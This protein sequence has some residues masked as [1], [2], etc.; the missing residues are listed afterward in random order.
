MLDFINNLIFNSIHIY[1][2]QKINK[3]MSTHNIMSDN[4]CSNLKW[5]CI[6][7]SDLEENSIPHIF[8]FEDIMNHLNESFIKDIYPCEQFDSFLGI[9]KY[10][11][12]NRDNYNEIHKLYRSK[13]ITINEN[14][15][16]FS[17]NVH[18]IIQAAKY[19]EVD[20][21]VELNKILSVNIECFYIKELENTLM[22]EDYKSFLFEKL[23]KIN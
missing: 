12:I 17:E 10:D 4:E 11:T 7:N 3:S 13:G 15:V 8:Y 14:T 22:D 19:K 23:N 16:D 21:S 6:W 9:G 18:P 1:N 20:I 5:F 2:N